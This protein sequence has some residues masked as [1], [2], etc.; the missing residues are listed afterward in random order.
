MA[1]TTPSSSR[2]CCVCLNPPASSSLNKKIAYINTIL[3]GIFSAVPTWYLSELLKG[4]CLFHSLR[5]W[6]EINRHGRSDISVK[7]YL[8]F[9]L[10]LLGDHQTLPSW[11]SLL[12]CFTGTVKGNN[13]VWS[14]CWHGTVL[15]VT[16]H[17]YSGT[18]I[19]G[20]FN[21]HPCQHW[22]KGRSSGIYGT[23]EEKARISWRRDKDCIP[24]TLTLDSKLF[25]ISWRDVLGISF[26]A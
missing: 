23:G 4:F 24:N 22:Q 26:Q 6:K 13:I 16:E 3:E 9:F 11:P 18:Q 15:T 20:A 7:N 5:G 12:E 19:T 21:P 10:S 17:L 8:C 25:P 1:L 14:P 2:I